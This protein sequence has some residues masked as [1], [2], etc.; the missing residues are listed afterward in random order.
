MSVSRTPERLKRPG[1]NGSRDGNLSVVTVSTPLLGGYHIGAL[2][3][4]LWDFA[5]DASSPG[6]NQ[7]NL[8][9]FINY[10]L[11]NGWALA[12][13]PIFVANWDAASGEQWT[14]PLGGGISKVSHFGR[15]PL[16]LGVQYYCNVERPEASGT[17]L[18]RLTVSLLYPQAPSSAKLQKAP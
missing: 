17:S 1:G 3:F 10:N 14:V 6:I 5:G 15:R 12:T 8:Q 2:V 7:F 18:L 11:R 9:P 4:Q 16:S 13:A